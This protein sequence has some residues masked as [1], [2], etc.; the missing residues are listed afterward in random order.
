MSTTLA[1]VRLLYFDGSGDDRSDADPIANAA[2]EDEVTAIVTEAKDTY[3]GYNFVA[4]EVRLGLHM[5]GTYNHPLILFSFRSHILT[6]IYV[7][8]PY[9]SS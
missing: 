8:I 9:Q 5:T 7:M 4:L 3:S 2:D 1:D 6:C